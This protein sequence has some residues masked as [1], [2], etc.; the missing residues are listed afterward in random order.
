MSSSYLLLIVVVLILG[1]G[2]QMLIKRTYKKWSQQPNQAGLSGAQA[3]RQML[4]DNG[5]SN[6]QI[7]QVGGELSDH[8]DPRTNVVSLSTGVYDGRSVSAVA[9]ACHECGH[10][11]QHARAYVPAKIRSP[12]VPVVSLASNLWVF[13]LIAGFFLSMLGLIYAAIIMFAAVIVFQ[14]VTLPVEFDASKRG[15]A[16]IQGTGW[17][18]PQE[19]AGASSV[20]RAAAMTYVAAAL[21]SVLQLVYLLGMARD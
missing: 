6:V 20:L 8:F 12:I 11:V 13:V 16:F 5:L 4:D 2:S 10:A 15:L 21:S 18:S 19:N 3:A 17:L 7:A 1:F 9:V 14:L